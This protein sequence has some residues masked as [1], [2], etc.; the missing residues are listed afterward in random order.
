MD[1][2]V[3]PYPSDKPIISQP[4]HY[5]GWIISIESYA[6]VSSVLIGKHDSNPEIAAQ[7]RTLA[8]K[9]EGK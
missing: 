1:I 3:H 5:D 7:L 9:V 8:D 4:G 6:T 2:R